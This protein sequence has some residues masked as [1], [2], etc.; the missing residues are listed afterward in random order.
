[1]S[2]L[3]KRTKL[4]LQGVWIS[5]CLALLFAVPMSTQASPPLPAVTAEQIEADW[6]RQDVVREVVNSGENVTTAEDA[7]GGCDGLKTGG[8]GF[9]TSHEAQPWWQVDLGQS[10]PLQRLLLFN[11]GDVFAA[12][13]VRI[14]VLLSDDGRD[15]REV[16]QHDGTV[17]LGQ[18]DGKP[19]SVPLDGQAARFLRLQL[20][21]TDYLHL[22]E[23][24]VYAAGRDENVALHCPAEQSSTS[25]WS[26]RHEVGGPQ[27]RKDFT[28]RTVSRG[29]QLAGRLQQLGVDV[30]AES[31]VLASVATRYECS[32]QNGLKRVVSPSTAKHAG[33]SAKCR[34][35]TRCWT[36]ARFCS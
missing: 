27:P 24:E 17:F 20:P 8:W 36:L 13:N 10:Q 32:A 6:N 16:Y 1:M 14:R 15:F 26:V 9:H 35:A 21:A 4:T 23:V 18:A 11:R 31:Q 22:D 5:A 34:C 33:R 2:P 7:A 3:Q 29:Q 25:T 19:L 12:R 28:A 30:S